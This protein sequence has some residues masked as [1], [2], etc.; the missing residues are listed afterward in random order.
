[1]KL[2]LPSAESKAIWWRL[3]WQLSLATVCG[4][5]LAACAG[6]EAPRDNSAMLPE[7]QRVS[8]VP[9][10]KPEGWENKGALGGLA[11]D[12]RFNGGQQQ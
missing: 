4:L 1:M 6:Q 3:G 11:N 12:P 8:D 7:D 5:M 9:W 10:N 2:R